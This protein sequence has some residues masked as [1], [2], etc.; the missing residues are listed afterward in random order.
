MHRPKRNAER[1]RRR[2]G[3]IV[4]RIELDAEVLDFII[5]KARWLS[6]ADDAAKV[7]EVISK[8][9]VVGGQS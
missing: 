6:E 1:Q 4:V 8:A 5:R 9:K 7:G 3:R 2:Q